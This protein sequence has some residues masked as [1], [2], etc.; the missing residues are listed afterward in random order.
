MWKK[1]IYGSGSIGA[2]CQNN[3]VRKAGFWKE[4]ECFLDLNFGEAFFS[5]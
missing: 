2:R 5:Q 4:L 3:G 1:I